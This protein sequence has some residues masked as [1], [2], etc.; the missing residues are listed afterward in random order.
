MT[1]WIAFFLTGLMAVSAWAFEWPSDAPLVRLNNRN[2]A[3][4]WRNGK[5]MAQRSEV[6]QVL[7]IARE[8]DPDVDLI[9]ELAKH[10]TKIEQRPDG[11][12]D[13]SVIKEL[14]SLPNSSGGQA[15][16][17]RAEFEAQQHAKKMAPKL[18]VIATRTFIDPDTDYIHAVGTIQNQGGSASSPCWAMGNFVDWYGHPFAKPDPWPLRSLAPGQSHTFEFFSMVQKD[19]KNHEKGSKYRCDITFQTTT[20]AEIEAAIQRIEKRK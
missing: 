11:T 8:G 12:I 7:R 4:S 18:V 2:I 10:K 17:F 1:R 14:A 13:I 3:V 9:E 15:A 5:P 19:D 16:Q 6:F 20:P